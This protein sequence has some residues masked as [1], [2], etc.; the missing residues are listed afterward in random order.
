M[1]DK[2]KAQHNKSIAGH[3]A[4]R[5][6]HHPDCPVTRYAD[7]KCRCDKES[8]ERIVWALSKQAARVQ[9]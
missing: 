7:G 2:A 9:S 5:I 6:S 8:L 1:K 4:S 3:I